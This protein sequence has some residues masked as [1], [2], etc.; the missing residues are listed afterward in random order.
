MTPVLHLF[1]GKIASGKST[2]AAQIACEGAVS[3]AEDA[4]LE[5]LYA[6]QMKTGADY[7]RCS[8]QLKT[9]MGPHVSSLLN[10]GLSVILDFPA[11]TVEQRAWMRDVLAQ[12]NAAHQ[13]HVLDTPDEICLARL[14][15]RNATGEHPFAVSEEQFRRFSSHFVRPAADEAFNLVMHRTPTG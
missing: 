5:G 3:I 14:A 1:C 7:L 11:N 12:T 13:L 6:D 15:H 4:W 8:A 9:V 10:A 2:L